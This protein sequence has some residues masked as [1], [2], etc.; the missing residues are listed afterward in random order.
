[1]SGSDRSPPI[2]EE[3]SPSVVGHS[4]MTPQ[5]H[6]KTT[7]RGAD[8]IEAARRTTASPTPKA[9]IRRLAQG[10]IH[11]RSRTGSRDRPDGEEASAARDVT[12]QGPTGR[13]GTLQHAADAL[14]SAAAGD[15]RSPP[16]YDG[17]SPKICVLF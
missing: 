15:R 7:G 9:M 5:N 13:R 10:G 4:L 6:N 14:N 12:R 8:S 17:Y 16:G 1:M 2:P 11:D 3:A